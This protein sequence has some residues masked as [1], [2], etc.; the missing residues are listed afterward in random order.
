MDDFVSNLVDA[1]YSYNETIHGLFSKKAALCP[2]N[3]AVIFEHQSLTYKELDEYS[4]ALALKIL[5]K[6]KSVNKSDKFMPMIAVCMHRSLEMIISLISIFKAGG[7]YIPINTTLSQQALQNFILQT[8]SDILL[9]DANQIID[10]LQLN[11]PRLKIK[12]QMFMDG[13]HLK[14]KSQVKPGDLA[15]VIYTSGSTGI[16]KGVAITH[17][18]AVNTLLAVNWRFNI[19]S[20]DRVLAISEYTFDLSVYDFFGILFAGGTVVLLE[21]TRVQDPSYWYSLICDHKITIWNSVPQLMA[22]LVDYIE[23]KK[24][25]LKYIKYALLSGDKIPVKLPSK[26]VTLNQHIVTF[27]LGGATEGSIWSIWYHITKVDDNW[28]TI[29]YGYAMPNQAIYILDADLNECAVNEPGEICI[30]GVGVALGYWLDYKRTEQQF[31]QHDIFGYIYKTGDMGVKHK[32]GYIE[33]LGR[34]D[35]QVKIQGY[36]VEL[37]EIEYALLQHEDIEQCVVT[38]QNIHNSGTSSKVLVAYYVSCR[39]ISEDEFK[40]HLQKSLVQHMIPNIYMFVERFTLTENGKVDVKTLPKPELKSNNIM[41]KPHTKTEMILCEIWKEAF[42]LESVGVRDDFYEIGGNSVTAIALVTQ[43][44]KEKYK[45]MPKDIYENTTIEALAKV[46]DNN[47]SCEQ[48]AER[49]VEVN[50]GN[51]D[52]LPIQKNFFQHVSSNRYTKPNHWNQSFIIKTPQLDIVKLEKSIVKLAEHHA[53]LRVKFKKDASGYSQHIRKDFSAPKLFKLDIASLK[54]TTEL[55]NHLTEYQSKFNI[56]DGNLWKVGYIYGYPDNSARIFFAA[57]HLIVDVF[58]GRI[59]IEDLRALYHDQALEK[60]HT[61][62]AKWSDFISNYAKFHKQEKLYWHRLISKAITNNVNNSN[63]NRHPIIRKLS[64][65]PKSRVDSILKAVNV[66]ARLGVSSLLLTSTLY[67][68]QKSKILNKEMIM[69]DVHGREH[70]HS[71]TD[72]S[73]TIGWFTCRFPF[74]H[75]L[76][77]SLLENIKDVYNSLAKV[78]NKGLGYG[79]FHYAQQLSDSFDISNVRFTFLGDMQIG[80]KDW[81]LTFEDTGIN[82][83]PS[84]ETKNLLSINSYLYDEKIWLYISSK[85]GDIETNHITTELHKSLDIIENSIEEVCA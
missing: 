24:L 74:Q 43:I 25:R 65:I 44:R 35:N 66:T 17:S 83:D 80:D 5:D 75:K 42:N 59:I 84:N 45:L 79:A 64:Y 8:E 23:T 20:N 27:S 2:E 70:L 41:V 6:L 56:L 28:H 37:G 19:N 51:I 46:I 71:N 81:H 67:A 18:S 34:V 69:L 62:F 30:G 22:L 29:P 11:I 14:P 61:S 53:M 15:Y 13:N 36:R 10:D 78:P 1:D 73:R 57:H 55:A 40:N 32:Y 77:S 54:S 12:H 26:M 68:M 76:F 33:F 85:L 31:I 52:F 47:S 16:P 9:T 72:L 50:I 60:E 38:S 63:I 3:I 39:E 82:I 48:I 49:N 7:A 58:S 4:D 21:Q